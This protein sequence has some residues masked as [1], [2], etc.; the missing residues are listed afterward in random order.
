LPASGSFPLS[1]PLP[2]DAPFRI[3]AIL[4]AWMFKKL[5][6][7]LTKMPLTFILRGSFLA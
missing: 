1:Q 3:F 4:A 2:G 7:R 6:Q 5:F